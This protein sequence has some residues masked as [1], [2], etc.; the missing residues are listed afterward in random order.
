LEE[1]AKSKLK[2]CRL[3]EKPKLINKWV[4]MLKKEMLVFTDFRARDWFL[5]QI[6]GASK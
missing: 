1:K 5:E 3:R 4:N 2:N 6:K